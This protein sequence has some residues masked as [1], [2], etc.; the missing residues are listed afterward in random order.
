MEVEDYLK[1][2]KGIILPIGS[3]EQHGPTGAIGTDALTAEAVARAVGCITGVL[4]A[5]TQV[6]GM[7]E[8]HLGFP[9]TISLTPETLLNV[10][11]DVVLS[12]AKNG[13]EKIYVINGHGGNIA[14]VKSAFHKIYST[15]LNRH[16]PVASRLRCKLISWFHVLEV[17]EESKKLYG[18]K[19]GQHATPSEISLTLHLEPSLLQKQHSLPD[20]APAGPITNAEDFRMRYPDGRMGSHSDL[21]KSEHGKILLDKA[22]N[23]L[24]E[25]LS[26]FLLE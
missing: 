5:P 10:V 13:F 12:L 4:V 18:D 3:T 19:E 22:A 15:A 2:C 23:A 7:A 17:F 20:P 16:L 6:F 25:D 26:K 11:H 8:H 1:T 9:G 14:T 24:A 21:A